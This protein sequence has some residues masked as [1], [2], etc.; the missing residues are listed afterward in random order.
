MNRYA[1]RGALA[2][3]AFFVAGIIL[4]MVGVTFFGDGTLLRSKQRAVAYFDG[5][6]SGLSVGAPVTFRGVRVGNVERIQLRIDGARSRAEIPVHL[7]LDP[8]AAQW[9]S[10]STPLDIAELV[11]HGLHAQ[12]ALQSFVTGQMY[13][14]LDFYP[15]RTARRPTVV[16]LEDQIPE[17]PTMRSEYAQ[18]LDFIQRLPLQ[19]IT[20]SL[21]G[22]IRGIEGLTTQ[23]GEDLPALRAD[24]QGVM[25]ELNTAIPALSR[26]I[27]AMQRDFST[28]GSDISEA[29]VSMDRATTEIGDDFAALAEDMRKTSESLR[30]SAQLVT[31]LMAE[32]SHTR[33]DLEVMV[34][35][36]SRAARSLRNL[37]ELLEEQPNR[38]IFSR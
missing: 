11:R 7:R 32:D 5:S 25:Q 20:E 19:E 38:L 14:E 4:V 21:L 29:I 35:D 26:D 3:G 13:V 10:D 9:A 36:L 16:V 2:V 6:L 12:L 30:T 37:S 15:E 31:E 23:L 18:A 27:T 24:L 17:I 1:S 34:H 28:F 8:R 22:A 33:A